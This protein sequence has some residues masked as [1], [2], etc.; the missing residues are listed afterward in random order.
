MKQHNMKNLSI[1][2]GFVLSLSTMAFFGDR[3]HRE[4]QRNE[5]E[6]KHIQFITRNNFNPVNADTVP[7]RGHDTLQR[8]IIKEDSLAKKNSLVRTNL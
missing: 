3:K 1:G 5:Q 6:L 8:A 4:V 7:Y 2:I